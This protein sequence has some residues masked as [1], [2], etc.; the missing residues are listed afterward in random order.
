MKNFFVTIQRMLS[1]RVKRGIV[2]LT[3]VPA[4]I[5]ISPDGRIDSKIMS[6]AKNAEW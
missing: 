6:L 4:L 5:E 1:F 2:R 3:H